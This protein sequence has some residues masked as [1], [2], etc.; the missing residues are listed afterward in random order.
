MI[1]RVDVNVTPPAAVMTAGQRGAKVASEVILS[2]TDRP[3][4][5]R[6]PGCLSLWIARGATPDPPVDNQTA[7][8]GSVPREAET[9]RNRSTA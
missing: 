9:N 8:G 7:G 5:A 4:S 3:A 6:F 1:T 2:R